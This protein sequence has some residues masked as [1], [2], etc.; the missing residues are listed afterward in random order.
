MEVRNFKENC[1]IFASLLQST[2]VVENILSFRYLIKLHESISK[3]NEVFRTLCVPAV[4]PDHTLCGQSAGTVSSK[5][6][7]FQNLLLI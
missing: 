6:L 2:P 4:R 3:S 5:K 7:Y 1:S